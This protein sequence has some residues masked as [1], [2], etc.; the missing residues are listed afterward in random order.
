MK[1][2]GFSRWHGWT[3]G[4][5]KSFW[6]S[7]HSTLLYLKNRIQ[8][9]PSCNHII[10]NFLFLFFVFFFFFFLFIF[11]LYETYLQDG[12]T[13]TTINS[14]LIFMLPL[15]GNFP[16]TWITLMT[17]KCLFSPFKVRWSIIFNKAPGFKDE[18]NVLLMLKQLTQRFQSLK[19]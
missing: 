12:T 9:T 1:E 18:G 6:Q 16:H 11:L 3:K 10:H 8:P 2:I 15:F 19:T 17:M 14:I 13:S 5:I 4:V 7:L